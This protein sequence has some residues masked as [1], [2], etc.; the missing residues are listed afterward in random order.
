MNA[1]AIVQPSPYTAESASPVPRTTAEERSK[2]RFI[3]LRDYYLCRETE[4]EDSW[5]NRVFWRGLG[6]EGRKQA[7]EDTLAEIRSLPDY[8]GPPMRAPSGPALFDADGN[9]CLEPYCRSDLAG[10]L[11]NQEHLLGEHPPKKAASKEERKIRREARRALAEHRKREDR[12]RWQ[13]KCDPSDPTDPYKGGRGW[14]PKL[15]GVQI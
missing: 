1:R 8:D 4:P 5:R 13:R 9:M 3:A 10:Y 7:S 11:A 12:A 2:W 15:A 6:T 14:C